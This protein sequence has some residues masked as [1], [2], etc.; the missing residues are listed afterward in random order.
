MTVPVDNTKDSDPGHRLA[1]LSHR[2]VTR[3][4]SSISAGFGSCASA[5]TPRHTGRNCHSDCGETELVAS[6]VYIC[7]D[8]R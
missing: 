3:R 7:T 8:L 2:L 6:A 5:T 1:V 4:R